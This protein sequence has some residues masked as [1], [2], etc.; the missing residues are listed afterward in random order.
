[1]KFEISDY[2]GSYLAMSLEVGEQLICEK[3]ALIYCDGEYSFENKFEAKSLKNWIAKVGGKSLS[4]NIYTAK[5][6]LR[7]ALATKDEAELF[8]IAVTKENPILFDPGLHF[9]RTVGLEVQLEKKD[10]KSTLNDG[11][12]LKTL[13]EGQLFLKGYGKIIEQEIDSEKPI[14]VDEEALIAFEDQLELKTI[15][16][17]MKEL[18]TSGEGFLFAI[19]GKGK[20]WLQTRQPGEGRSSGGFVEGIFSFLK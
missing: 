8:S 1:M 6:S 16:K 2:P 13:G 9:A 12:K 14:Y 3:G 7:M 5:E 18:I 4:Y 15:S 10:L 20:I 17:G 19:S 11:L